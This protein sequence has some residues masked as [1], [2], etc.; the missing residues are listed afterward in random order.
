MILPWIGEGRLTGGADPVKV[1]GS[2]QS[3]RIAG[4]LIQLAGNLNQIAVIRFKASG[5]RFKVGDF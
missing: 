1:I 4:D 3:P 2:L 5:Q